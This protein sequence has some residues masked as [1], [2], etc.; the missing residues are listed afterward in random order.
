MI[1]EVVSKSQDLI[2]QTTSIAVIDQ[3]S[4]TVAGNAIKSL[5]GMIKQVS[6]VFDPI[7]ERAHEAHREAIAQRAKF[8]EPLEVAG[9]IIN[10]RMTT[11]WKAETD[12]VNAERRRIQLEQQ[13]EQDRLRKIA[14]DEAIAKAQKLAEAGKMKQAEKVLEKPVFVPPPVKVEMPQAPRSEG[15]SYSSKWRVIVDDKMTL[16]KAVV[17]CKVPSSLLNENQTMLDAMARADKEKFNVP[18]CRAVE[19]KIQRTRI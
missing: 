9:K 2:N 4:Y 1:N 6:S 13:K 17:E 19:E 18:G 14:E 3:V 7:V 12:R 11:W 10:G 5:K 8:L 16:I 15:I